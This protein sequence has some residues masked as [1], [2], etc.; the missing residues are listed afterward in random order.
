MIVTV[1]VWQNLQYDIQYDKETNWRRYSKLHQKVFVTLIHSSCFQLIQ[2]RVM[3]R[4]SSLC[5]FPLRICSAVGG[6]LSSQLMGNGVNGK[7]GPLAQVRVLVDIIQVSERACWSLVT[8]GGSSLQ[9]K[10]VSFESQNI[11]YSM[12]IFKWDKRWRHKS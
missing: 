2:E 4:A 3:K 6:I 12:I 7:H 1:S 11:M 10:Q 5:P 8:L 9:S